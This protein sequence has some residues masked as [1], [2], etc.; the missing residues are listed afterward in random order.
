MFLRLF[1]ATGH[2]LCGS[3][4][5]AKAHQQRLENSSSS[6]KRTNLMTRGISDSPPSEL[7]LK[8]SKQASC[9]FVST[10]NSFHLNSTLLTAIP[11]YLTIHNSFL[12]SSLLI[13]VDMKQKCP[14]VLKF[15]EFSAVL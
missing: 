12:P 10:S 8:A 4:P 3:I 5:Q 9:N 15:M 1:D 6:A 13:G 7:K 11:I 14:S 2:H